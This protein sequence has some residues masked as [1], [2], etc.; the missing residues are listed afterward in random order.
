MKVSFLINSQRQKA[1]EFA[2]GIPKPKVRRRLSN[3]SEVDMNNLKV[4]E[5]NDESMDDLLTFEKRNAS[6]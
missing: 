5:E 6:Y 2:K 1:L 3:D 4:I